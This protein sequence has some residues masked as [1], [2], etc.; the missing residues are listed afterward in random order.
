MDDVCEK[1]VTQ[2]D[3]PQRDHLRQSSVRII[4]DLPIPKGGQDGARNGEE[5]DEKRAFLLFFQDHL[6]L[7]HHSGQVCLLPQPVSGVIVFTG[8]KHSLRFR[9]R[10]LKNHG[11]PYFFSILCI[12]RRSSC[13]ISKTLSALEAAFPQV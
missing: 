2:D 12:A 6:L 13:L 9:R 7:P 8:A 1:S 11:K 3:R 10:Y 5:G 4:E